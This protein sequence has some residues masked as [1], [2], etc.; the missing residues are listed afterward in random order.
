MYWHCLYC[1][2]HT[3]N[4][5]FRF[6]TFTNYLTSLL[7]VFVLC[8]HLSSFVSY[9]TLGHLRS[10]ELQVGAVYSFWL[11]WQLAGIKIYSVRQFP[12]ISI[13]APTGKTA[14][15]RKMID[16]FWIAATFS[17]SVQSLGE[18]ELRAP[19]VGA[20]ISVFCTSRLVC[21]RVWDIVQTSIAWRSMGRFWY[22]FQRVFQNRSFCQIHYIVLI[23]VARW[24]HSFRGIAVKN[25]E[26]SE[27]RRKSLCAPLRIDSWKNWK[28]KGAETTV[29]VLPLQYQQPTFYD[30]KFSSFIDEA[31]FQA[32]T[33][34][35]CRECRHPLSRHFVEAKRSF[36]LYKRRRQT[37]WFI[38]NPKSCHDTCKDCIMSS[39]LSHSVNY[40][41]VEARSKNIS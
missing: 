14:L 2:E 27:N 13:F 36:F 5:V 24:R 40:H 31:T 17:I 19:G 4:S 20:K 26:K 12:K 6:W 37:F 9:V 11:P 3:V 35:T 33:I 39:C 8:L 7:C 38:H 10:A 28:N 34:A 18:I 25:C 1:L 16:T 21:L 29:S 30:N 15:D 22:G 41:S 32:G 23:F